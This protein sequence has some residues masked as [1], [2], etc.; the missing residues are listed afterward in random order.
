MRRSLLLA[1]A[2]FAL[3]PLLPAAAAA[4]PA[5]PTAGVGPVA[6]VCTV[7]PRPVPEIVGLFFDPAGTPVATPSPAAPIPSEDA[8]PAGEP[9]DEE[10]AAA[11]DATLR[12]WIVCLGEG[13][14]A[15]GYALMTEEFAA[16]FGPNLAN[17]AEDTAAEVAAL[18]EAQ[19]AV[20]P[21]AG[22]T[23]GLPGLVGPR[24]AEILED[25]RAAGIWED[26]QGLAHVVFEQQD[27]RWLIDA[28]SE[29]E[30][31]SVATPGA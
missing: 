23:D 11:I 6:V 28:L 14:T 31:G 3:I 16:E 17:P 18:L 8:L 7:E 26:E 20:P 1:P 15:R 19:L 10:T 5:T 29:I 2:A 13:Q 24:N 12:Q 9:V 30:G 27:G 25:G 21:S 22:A 4:Q